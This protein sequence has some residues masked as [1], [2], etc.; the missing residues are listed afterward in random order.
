[1]SDTFP[2]TLQGYAALEQE[3]KQLKTVERPKISTRIAE[4]RE[5]GDL[6]E[7]AEYHAAKEE[8]SFVEGRIGELEDKMA[9]AQVIDVSKLD[10]D[11]VKFG[12]TVGLL[13]DDDKKV[14]YKIVGEYEADIKKHM[15]SIVSPLARALI[16]KKVGDYVEVVVPKGVTGYEIFSV[17]YVS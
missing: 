6:K 4:A 14:T 9:R 17:Q 16:G 12:A 5:H 8:Q 15:I 7:N 2:I 1:M 11:I 10:G 13:D 3:L